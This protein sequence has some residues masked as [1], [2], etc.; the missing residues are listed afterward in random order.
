MRG[1]LPRVSALEA[2]MKTHSW[3]MADSKLGLGPA[4]WW[5]GYG[6]GEGKSSSSEASCRTTF[7]FLNV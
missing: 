3:C 5:G 4:S 6:G 1:P 2:G 7:L